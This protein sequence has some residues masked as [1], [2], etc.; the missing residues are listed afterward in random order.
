M[1]IYF[2]IAVALMGLLALAGGVAALTCGWVRPKS[3]ELIVRPR[4][5]GWGLVAISFCAFVLATDWLMLGD[6]GLRSLGQAAVV[7]A[8]ALIS[9]MTRASRHPADVELEEN[10]GKDPP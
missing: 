2:A 5:Y 9:R 8:L 1:F 3:R 4:L 6:R 7:V 10:G